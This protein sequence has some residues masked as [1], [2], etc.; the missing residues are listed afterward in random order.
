V[1]DFSESA[2][3][4]P[5]PVKFGGLMQGMGH[6]EDSSGDVDL[7]K[8]IELA[9]QN[10]YRMQQV[11]YASSTSRR[12]GCREHEDEE[13]SYYCFGCLTTICPECA[14]HGSHQ[15]HE[16]K[17]IKKAIGDIKEHF[18]NVVDR[19][20]KVSDRHKARNQSML[21]A[22]SGLADLHIQHRRALAD[23]F[24]GIRNDLA[25]QEAQ[26]MAKLEELHRSNVEL[27]KHRMEEG[28]L[29]KDEAEKLAQ[30]VLALLKK[31][32]LTILE[33]YGKRTADFNA[34]IEKYEREPHDDKIEG[35]RTV[36][37]APML[38]LG[39]DLTQLVT[40]LDLSTAELKAAELGLR[41]VDS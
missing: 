19:V 13:V 11:N 24:D 27:V 37:Q 39:S 17:Q 14:I 35:L 34:K 41:V 22:L 1:G 5:T 16:V 20:Q 31:D 38:H 30:G 33:E 26:L 32:E 3:V 29:K 2:P 21:N 15:G 28:R 18:I 8:E 25:R 6:S 9:A 23:F 10:A 12:N 4:E 7:L 40:K 36:D